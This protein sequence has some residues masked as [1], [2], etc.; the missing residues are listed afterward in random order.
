M[1][2]TAIKAADARA[3]C[4]KTQVEFV[5]SRDSK[6]FHILKSIYSNIEQATKCFPPSY[7]ITRIISTD[8]GKYGCMDPVIQDLKKAGY[9]AFVDDSG[10]NDPVLKVSW[11]E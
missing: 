5:K 1:H 2:P 4:E 8:E 10:D 7:E 6:V 3:K 9:T 11:K